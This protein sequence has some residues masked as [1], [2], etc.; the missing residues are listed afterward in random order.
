[1]FLSASV[2]KHNMTILILLF[3]ANKISLQTGSLWGKC[4]RSGAT[5]E[6][7]WREESGHL[8]H[9]FCLSVA[10]LSQATIR[11]IIEIIANVQEGWKLFCTSL[12]EL[13]Q[14]EC[15]LPWF[16]VSVQIPLFQDHILF[17]SSLELKNMR[18]SLHKICLRVAAVRL[19]GVR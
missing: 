18:T 16:P 2:N 9:C 4:R 8:P 19:E 6:R 11:C 5:T 3:Q 10:A 14:E 17:V 15:S 1:M 7:S 12:P 13:D